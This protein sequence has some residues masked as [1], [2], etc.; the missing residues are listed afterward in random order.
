MAGP[1]HIST[2]VPASFDATMDDAAFMAPAGVLRPFSY[3]RSRIIARHVNAMLK[4]GVTLLTV[5]LEP[6]LKA[7]GLN[8]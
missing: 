5:Y 4:G 1:L 3:L 2:E 8:L 7:S 6:G